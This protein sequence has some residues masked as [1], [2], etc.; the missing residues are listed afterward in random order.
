MSRLMERRGMAERP[1]GFRSALRNWVA[2]ATNTPF[3]T[4]ETLLAHKV[5]N[6]VSR[7][8]L[9]TDFLDER[10]KLLQQWAAFVT[11]ERAPAPHSR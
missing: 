4:A 5:G 1:H 2:E 9:R 6:S 10:R 11:G 8:Y 3:E 7:A